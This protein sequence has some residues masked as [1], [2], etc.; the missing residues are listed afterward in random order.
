MRSMGTR[1]PD[2]GVPAG[3][4]RPIPSIAAPAGGADA[5]GAAGVPYRQRD[6]RQ[7]RARRQQGRRALPQTSPRAGVRP[8]GE[9][10]RDQ[11]NVGASAARGGQ[12]RSECTVTRRSSAGPAPVGRGGPAGPVRA[13]NRALGRAAGQNGK[14]APP[15][16]PLPPAF[17]SGRCVR[18]GASDNGERSARRC[19]AAGRPTQLPTDRRCARR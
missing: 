4:V 13:H 7:A 18:P 15:A 2:A 5:A 6:H 8:G 10:R 3:E 11:H 14:V 1:R 12:F 16:A 9:D 19:H 17:E